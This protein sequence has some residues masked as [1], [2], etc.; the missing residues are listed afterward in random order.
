MKSKKGEKG[1]CHNR[2]KEKKNTKTWGVVKEKSK[3]FKE[4]KKSEKKRQQ[5]QQN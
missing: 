1:K 2:K 4:N 5:G 3:R